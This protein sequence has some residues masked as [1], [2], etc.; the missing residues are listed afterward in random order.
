VHDRSDFKESKSMT[1][2]CVMEQRAQKAENGYK[3]LGFGDTLST[4]LTGLS[5][6]LCINM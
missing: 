4:F 6:F 5:L 3:P 2:G 1:K